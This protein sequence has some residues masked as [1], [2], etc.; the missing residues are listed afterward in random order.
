MIRQL[1]KIRNLLILILFSVFYFPFS[2]GSAHAATLYTSP[3]TGSYAVGSTF[4]VGIFVSSAGESANAVS[5]EISFPVDKLQVLSVSKSGSIINLWVQ[6]PSFSSTEGLINF[7]G[8]VLNPGFTGSG[9]KIITINFKN[10]AAGNATLSFSSGS[11][12]A[13]DGKGTNILTGLGNAVFTIAESGGTA[14]PP[15]GEQTNTINKSTKVP[16]APIIYSPTHPDSEKWYSQNS[17]EFR[18]NLTKDIIGVSAY[19]NDKPLSNPGPASDGLFDSKTYQ[20]LKDGIWYFHLKLKNSYGWGAISHFKFQI[21]TTPPKPFNI[22]VIDGDETENPCPTIVFDTTDSDSGINYYKV[23]VGEGNFNT[24]IADVVK[25]NP[26]TLS[27][28]DPGKKTILVEAFDKA[29]NYTIATKEITFKQFAAPIFSDY[30]KK[31]LTTETLTLRGST[32]PNADVA[33]WLQREKDEPKNQTVKS[34]EKGEFVF[35]AGEKL[36]DGIYKIW[37][38]ATDSRG[39]KSELSEKITIE[40]SLPYVLKIGRLVIDYLTVIN[41]LIILLVGILVIIAYSWYR[42]SFWRKRIKKETRET[43]EVVRRAFSTLKEQ[44]EKQVAK[45]DGNPRLNKREKE[46]CNN[47]KS[48]L[49]NSEKFIEK[50]ISDIEKELK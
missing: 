23:K 7:E 50:E 42:I 15:A 40:V 16:P 12:L 13:N 31:I 9:G 19:L 1:F 14:Q 33:V 38:Q 48:A 22:K 28:Q 10:K 6:E 37:A 8:I 20:N 34:D 43:K 26:Y 2:A 21:D 35:I 4:S 39:A 18:W 25:S 17:P 29:G 30:P 44:V 11:I 45:M 3:S 5:G 27:C 41:T 49:K 32:V 24:V 46:V 47:L 36:K